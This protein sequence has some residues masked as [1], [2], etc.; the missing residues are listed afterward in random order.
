VI[1]M[2]N[3]RKREFNVR[4]KE[5]AGSQGLMLIYKQ[6]RTWYSPEERQKREKEMDAPFVGAIDWWNWDQ[7]NANGVEMS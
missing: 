5:A 7:Q 2:F 1:I 3:Y 6:R 4:Q